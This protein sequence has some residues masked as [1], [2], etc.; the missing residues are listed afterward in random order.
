M[1]TSSVSKR[2]RVQGIRYWSVALK[3]TRLS[4]WQLGMSALALAAIL[5]TVG[6]LLFGKDMGPHT[7]ATAAGILGEAALVVLVLDRMANSQ[8]K[9]EWNFVGAVV[10]HGVAAC[11]VDVVRLCCIRWSPQAYGANIAR[12][13]EFVQIARL[14]I[15]NLRSNLEGLALGA[16]PESYKQARRI[17]FRLAWLADYLSNIPG[18]PA[19]PGV[20]LHLVDSTIKLIGQFFRTTNEVE[21]A[22]VSSMV[23]SVIAA[24]DP[25]RSPEGPGKAADEFFAARMRAQNEILRRHPAGE[26]GIW[27]DIDQ[28]LAPIYFAIDYIMFDQISRRMASAS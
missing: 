23:T 26:T 18:K 2:F 13:G 21:F 24:D 27:Y 8:R 12:Y 5:V 4:L 10:S 17:E 20:E 15:M 14:H 7:I 9:R 25:I 11:M 19:K 16:E 22:T 1:N 6:F 3:N 28:E